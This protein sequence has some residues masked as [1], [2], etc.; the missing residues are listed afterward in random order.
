MTDTA[1][2]PDARRRGPLIV[3]AVLLAVLVLV[4]VALVQAPSASKDGARTLTTTFFDDIK[5][6]RYVDAAAL[7]CPGVVTAS[8]LQAGR[9]TE[10]KLGGDLVSGTVAAEKQTRTFRFDWPPTE[11]RV[12]VT[13]LVMYKRGAQQHVLEVRDTSAGLRICALDAHA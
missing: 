8:I 10:L 13:Y 12:E 2:S 4:V 11:A 5:S 3:L 7:T 9:E 1:P 6:G